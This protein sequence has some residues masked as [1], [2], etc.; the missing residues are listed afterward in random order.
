MDAQSGSTTLLRLGPGS[1]FRTLSVAGPIALSGL[2]AGCLVAEPSIAGIVALGWIL[3]LWYC[4]RA[5]KASVTVTSTELHVVTPLREYRA[6]WSS[7]AQTAWHRGHRI[8]TTMDG[9]HFRIPQYTL[10][11]L[12]RMVPTLLASRRHLE[13]AMEQAA[14]AGTT[15]NMVDARSASIERIFPA[16]TFLVCTGVLV[17]AAQTIAIV[18]S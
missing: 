12:V 17:A 4:W 3:G 14:R 6:P 11:P 13:E 2:A 9:R 10:T 5:T 1:E 16:P 7:V 8:V 18:A 15:S